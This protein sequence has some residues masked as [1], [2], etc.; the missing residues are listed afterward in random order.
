MI[1]CALL[2]EDA[3][4]DSL[5][6]LTWL[7]FK[8]V[9]LQYSL[10]YLSLV[11]RLCR[12]SVCILDHRSFFLSTVH[13]DLDGLL[14]DNFSFFSIFIGP[15][16]NNLDRSLVTFISDLTAFATAVTSSILAGRHTVVSRAL[17]L[18]VVL[19]SSL[20]RL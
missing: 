7:H 9:F 13:E 12:R 4:G 19:L 16:W 2:V 6:L 18:F 8:I 14:H 15:D 17:H 1:G 10:L 11:I 20:R 5:I 3:L